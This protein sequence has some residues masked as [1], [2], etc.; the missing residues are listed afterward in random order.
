MSKEEK[1]ED[2]W[3]S[4]MSKV[5]MLASLILIV[6]GIVPPLVVHFLKM[7]SV[8]AGLFGG[9]GVLLIAG[10]FFDILSQAEFFKN[11]LDL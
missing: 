10:V 6:I 3:D 9:T 7:P 8:V 4:N 1:A 11:K 5:I 2:F